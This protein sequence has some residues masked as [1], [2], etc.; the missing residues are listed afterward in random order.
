MAACMAPEL[1]H[2]TALASRERS[3]ATGN[4]PT[5]EG[6]I[7]EAVRLALERRRPTVIEVSVAGDHLTDIMTPED[8][9]WHDDAFRHVG[10]Q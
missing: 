4:S 9:A 2:R 7:Q 5:T 1:T 3:V 6:E 10:R 8:I